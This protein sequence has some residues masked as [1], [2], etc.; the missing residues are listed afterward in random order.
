MNSMNTLKVCFLNRE[1]QAA[2]Y[3]LNYIALDGDIG[4]MVNGAG[5]AMA[6]MDIIK[7]YHCILISMQNIL[8]CSRLAVWRCSYLPPSTNFF[9][10]EG[11][12]SI[13]CSTIYLSMYH[14]FYLY[15]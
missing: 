9:D 7:V 11:R 12:N 2:E 5:L 8:A 3:N 1:V 4:C 13:H 14:S 15:T 6:T 10:V